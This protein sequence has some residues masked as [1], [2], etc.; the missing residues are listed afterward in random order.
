[1]KKTLLI[2]STAVLL[3]ACSKKTES[4]ET[5]TLDSAVTS[6]KLPATENTPVSETEK[7]SENKNL[8]IALFKEK[9]IPAAMLKGSL[10]P[11][12]MEGES[13]I[14]LVPNMED[15]RKGN[16]LDIAYIDH[17]LKKIIL[18]INGKFE[19]LK[20]TG[21]DQ[22]E[23]SEYKVSFTTTVPDKVPEDIEVLAYAF[24]GKLDVKRKSDNVSKSLDFFMGGL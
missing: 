14:E 18:K 2:I 13:I 20:E 3:A 24:N 15:F 21:E 10:H 22:Y 16:G 1:M 23:N 19:E 6:E 4:K 5:K 8:D 12:D 9:D 17:S 11:H 7:V